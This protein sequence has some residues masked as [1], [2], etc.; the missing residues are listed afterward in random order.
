MIKTRNFGQ[1]APT[2]SAPLGQPASPGTWNL[3]LAAVVAL[4]SW[5]CGLL[6]VLAQPANSFDLRTNKTAEATETGAED[7]KT[8]AQKT[9]TE[10]T[11][12][13]GKKVVLIPIEQEI[14]HPVL[15]LVRNGVDKAKKI[16][17]DAVLLNMDTMGG[18][19]DVMMDIVRAL[20]ELTCPVITYVKGDA[21]SAGALIAMCTDEIYMND[22][23]FI[24][25]A[26][27]IIYGPGGVQTLDDATREK[28]TAPLDSFA[29]TY[30][31]K[32]GRDPD[33]VTA[34]IRPETSLKMAEI[35]GVTNTVE[36][37][38]AGKI[39][40]LNSQEARQNVVV[41]GTRVPLVSNGT[42]AS[43]ADVLTAVGLG[44]AQVVPLKIVWAH[45]FA[46][47]VTFLAPILMILALAFFKQEI[48]TPGFGVFGLLGFLCLVLLFY[49][50]RVA[51]L[52]GYEEII[53]FGLGMAF[54]GFEVFVIPGFGIAGIIGLLMI[55]TSMFMAMVRFLPS[56][57]SAPGSGSKWIPNLN[58]IANLDAALIN[59]LIAMVGMSGVIMALAALLPKMKAAKRLTLETA[60]S[61]A[62]GYTGS[63]DQPLSAGE[64]GVAL[65]RLR[66]AGKAEFDGTVY[67][68]FTE[69]G[70]VEKGSNIR[71]LSSKGNR[72]IVE[73][74]ETPSPG[75]STTDT[76]P[77]P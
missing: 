11:T 76:T 63:S 2:R 49:G 21:Y 18:R 69:G 55:L 40:V 14:D 46:R 6:S 64:H 62:A 5:S 31:A 29:R 58:N 41:N 23:A 50:H 28:L 24:G 67:D 35:P 33:I 52:A 73:A 56:G 20:D 77:T 74:I 36:I 32:V 45:S 53:L 65:S 16:N 3:G 59:M 39:L 51:G 9:A 68:V 75:S 17:A 43:V 7:N 10:Q 13:D 54:I 25:D 48:A 66:P 4:L 12:A 30:A 8:G 71:V 27:A 22:T 57:V 37:C 44:Q 72:I 19:V 1:P 15:Y 42:K 60:T 61:T 47:I 34:M 38:K 26:I 70:Y